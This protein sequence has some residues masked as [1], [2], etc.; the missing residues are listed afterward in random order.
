MEQT[1]AL[2]GLMESADLVKMIE[3]ITS[4]GILE[5]LTASS[6]SGVR[7][8]LRSIRESI[9]SSHDILAADLISRSRINYEP[10]ATSTKLQTN[11]QPLLQNRILAPSA[12]APIKKDLRSTL[13]KVI[14]G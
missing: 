12:G 2:Q 9:L 3:D 5:R 8:T 10:N 11:N 13:E 4:P 14:E 7:I 1:K 6:F